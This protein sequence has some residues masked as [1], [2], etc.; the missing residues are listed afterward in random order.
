[1]GA[2]APGPGP[3]P[4]RPALAKGSGFNFRRPAE[5][6]QAGYGALRDLLKRGAAAAAVLA[7]LLALEQGSAAWAD[8]MRLAALKREVLA[9]YQRIDPEAG[10]IVD[11]VSQLKGKIAAARRASAGLGEAGSGAPALALLR[12]ISR[13]APEELL[14]T[15]LSLER[16]SFSLKGQVASFDSLE[17]MKKA[18]GQ[19]QLVRSVAIDATE[20]LKEGQG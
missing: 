18:F 14:V 2:G 11:P 9:A 8:R 7:A 3:G 4:G 19:S 1:M 15:S 20:Q 17:A 6:A 16:G 10:R 5:A 13:L 12:E